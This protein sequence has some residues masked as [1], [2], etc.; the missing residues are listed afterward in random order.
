[1]DKGISYSCISLLT[2]GLSLCGVVQCLVPLACLLRCCGCLLCCVSLSS[3]LLGLQ[4]CLSAVLGFCSLFYTVYICNAL[5]DSL[6]GLVHSG[7]AC[8]ASQPMIG[9]LHSGIACLVCDWLIYDW[10]LTKYVHCELCCDWL[11]F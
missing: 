8:L 1:M 6:S 9:Q 7:T 5:W 3:N 4:L 2:S 11:P 10:S